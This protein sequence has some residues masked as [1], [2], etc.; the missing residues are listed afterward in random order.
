VRT[1]N[2]LLVVVILI[3]IVDALAHT[4]KESV[5]H[6]DEIAKWTKTE[7]PLRVSHIGSELASADGFWQSTNTSK[8]K[9]LVSPIVV[10]IT[11]T[12]YDK[13]C[14]EAEASVFLGAIL[15]A[16]LLEYD[17]T[18]WTNDGIVADD[19]DPG[20]CGIGHRLSLD[21]KS[22]SVTVTD[23]PMKVDNSADC[24]VFQDAN[25]Y[26]LRGGQIMLYP[27]AKWE[28]LETSPRK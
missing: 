2:V 10:K 27:P 13:T 22:N 17:I 14:R 5:V 8:D 4:R 6:A 15:Q 23:Y 16:D 28:P 21:F 18:S 26:S 3:G 11:C 24:K 20:K 19:E 1:T 7:I 25:S 9:Q 12:S